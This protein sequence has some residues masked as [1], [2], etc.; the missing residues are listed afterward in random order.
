MVVDVANAIDLSW[1]SEDIPDTDVLYMRVHW[2][3][4]DED[5]VLIPG[6]FKDIGGG[7]STD[8]DKYSNPDQ[9][10]ARAADPT[11]NAVIAMSVGEVRTVPGQIVIHTPSLEF[12]NRAHTDVIGEK[13]KN[14]EVRLKFTRIYRIVISYAGQHT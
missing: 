2:R 6:A 10:R 3:Q 13:K 1:E 11:A 5:G 12:N 14:P 4:L 8:W 9:T 7:M